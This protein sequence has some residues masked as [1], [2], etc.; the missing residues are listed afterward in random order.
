[1]SDPFLRPEVKAWLR[2][3]AET[4]AALALAALGVLWFATGG[5]V[6]AWAG[7]ALALAAGAAAYVAFRRA[8]FGSPGGGVGV[9]HL[10]E[11][12][13]TYFGPL[14]GGSVDVQEVVSVGIDP[15]HHPAHWV[16]RDG[17]TDL[18]IPVDAEG[19][20]ALFDVFALLPG[21][22]LGAVRAASEEVRDLPAT[23]WRRDEVPGT[24]RLPRA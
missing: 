8:R 20:G 6:L 14:S 5:P 9:V 10:D 22:D 12:R 13:L 21:F 24:R 11:G 19:A 18:L 4:L 16:V 3:W 23:L 17:E 2:R 15:R 7:A 1:M